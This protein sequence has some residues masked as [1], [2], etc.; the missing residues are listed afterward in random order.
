MFLISWEL[1][2]IRI[3]T[4]VTSDSARQRSI[5]VN[6]NYLGDCKQENTTT[7]T[8]KT[9]QS[10]NKKARFRRQSGAVSARA[11]AEVPSAYIATSVFMATYCK[12]T[13]L[14][15]DFNLSVGPSPVSTS[16]YT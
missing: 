4:Q 2:D 10:S 7:T 14:P 16:L 9:K 8:A 1:V 3:Q 11:T 15:E 13:S 6:S 5:D 12:F